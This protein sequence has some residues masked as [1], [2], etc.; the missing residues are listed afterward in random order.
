MDIQ[1]HN[2]INREAKGLMS[3]EADNQIARD[4]FESS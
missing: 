3:A 4:S 2:N 1:K